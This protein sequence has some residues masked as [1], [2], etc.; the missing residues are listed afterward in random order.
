M[1]GVS[2]ERLPRGRHRLSREQVARSQRERLLE[3][4]VAA[5]A[6]QGFATVSVATVLRRAGVSRESFYEHFDNKLDCFLSAYAVAADAVAL[7]IADA[8]ARGGGEDRRARLDRVIARYLAEL[9]A[10]PAVAQPFLEEIYA[11]GPE[12]VRLRAETQARFAAAVATIAGATDDRQ[13]FA[14]EAL[15]AAIAGLVTQRIGAGRATE[16]PELREP[17]LE[18]SAALLGAVGL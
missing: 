10:E 6:E 11:A 12:A 8:A 18:L 1:E 2:T 5:V 9:A 3:A 17:L 15:V 7:A 4:M 13:R 14:C 16:L